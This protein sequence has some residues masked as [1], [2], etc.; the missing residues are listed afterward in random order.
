MIMSKRITRQRRSSLGGH[1]AGTGITGQTAQQFDDHTIK[2][3][4][5]HH[6]RDLPVNLNSK[7]EKKKFEEY[8]KE[9]SGEV[10]VYNIKDLEEASE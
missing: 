8:C 5:Q 6:R 3:T 4:V 7:E 2:R 9:M 1:W 10:K